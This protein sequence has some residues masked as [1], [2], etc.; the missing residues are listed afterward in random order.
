MFKIISHIIHLLPSS[1]KE[2]DPV[3]SFDEQRLLSVL[4]GVHPQ[5]LPAF[6]AFTGT[7]TAGRFAG[8][9]KAWLQKCQKADC[10]LPGDC[11]LHAL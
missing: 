4:T 5:A 7:D 6:H 11:L 8:I 3:V 2:G 9:G 10:L 1:F